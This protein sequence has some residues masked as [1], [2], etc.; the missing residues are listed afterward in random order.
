MYG[1]DV[2]VSQIHKMPVIIQFV[3]EYQITLLPTIGQ[4]VT[5]SSVSRLFRSEAD[6]GHRVPVLPIE[7][8]GRSV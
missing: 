1:G 4:V 2:T 3:Y 5:E 6:S 7:E 8:K